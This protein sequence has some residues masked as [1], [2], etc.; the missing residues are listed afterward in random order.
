[1]TQPSTQ[2]KRT[3]ERSIVSCMRWH[4]PPEPQAG[5]GGIFPGEGDYGRVNYPYTNWL[6]AYYLTMN[7]LL[8]GGS[9]SEARF[10]WRRRLEQTRRSPDSP[11][12]GGCNQALRVWQNPSRVPVYVRAWVRGTSGVTNSHG[13]RIPYNFSQQDRN[14][15]YDWGRTVAAQLKRYLRQEIN[16]TGRE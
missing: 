1:M 13:I 12:Q 10:V 6:K 7:H 3:A 16:R 8:S 4:N 9:A 11:G 5:T 14:D 2:Q 15:A